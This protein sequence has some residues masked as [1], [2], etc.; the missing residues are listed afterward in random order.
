[1][2]LPQSIDRLV[3]PKRADSSA[4]VRLV[5]GA[6]LSFNLILTA[7]CT[8]LASFNQAKIEE[9][10]LSIENE[11]NVKIN[12]DATT[13]LRGDTW[14]TLDQIE[15]AL[16]PFPAEYR[17]KV[18]EIRVVEDFLSRF[19]LAALA[20][21]AYVEDEREDQNRIIFIKN[22][23]L[24]EDFVGLVEL[25]VG[26]HLAHESWHSVEYYEIERLRVIESGKD[27]GPETLFAKLENLDTN[28][29]YVLADYEVEPLHTSH[30]DP[31]PSAAHYLALIKGWLYAPFGDVNGDS[32][33]DDDDVTYIDAHWDKFDATGDGKITYEDVSKGTRYGYLEAESPLSLQLQLGMSLEILPGYR[34]PG[35][36]SFYAKNFPWEDRAET[37]EAALSR[38]FIP[39]IYKAG[40]PR[41]K[42][43]KAWKGLTSIKSKDPVL[44]RKFELILQYIAH[45]EEQQ[46]LSRRWKE[47]YMQ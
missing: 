28:A 22:K 10:R 27:E 36:C 23:N 37:L 31:A 5:V 9:K 42:Q 43:E 7:G 26:T 20:V 40:V 11:L 18:A 35:F 3:R 38:G 17:R 29:A 44:G 12:L 15:A 41:A 32:K 4:C 13:P 45:Q 1:M 30:R 19:G 46:N 21:G 34:P 39:Y 47:T 16:K 14:R 8:S 33:I 25:D 6:I 2:L 24:V